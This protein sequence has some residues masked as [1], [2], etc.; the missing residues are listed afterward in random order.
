[1]ARAFPANVSRIKAEG[2][3][4]IEWLILDRIGG[5]FCGC[6]SELEGNELDVVERS[7]AVGQKSYALAS[8]LLVMDKIIV[9]HAFPGHHRL[10][11]PCI[12]Y[13]RATIT[14]TD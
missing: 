5:N 8:E 9:T 6:G 13:Y 12:E 14:S 3:V 2:W 7:A 10:Y 4:K 1:M 11:R